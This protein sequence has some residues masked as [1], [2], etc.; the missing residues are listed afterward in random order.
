MAMK[1]HFVLLFLI[2]QL[3]LSFSASDQVNTLESV[4]DL[5]QS[6]YLTVN[7][8]PCVRLLNLSGEIGCASHETSLRLSELLSNDTGLARKVAGVL[9]ESSTK[10][11]NES[12]GFSPVEK[13]PQAEF[14]PYQKL[15][16]EWNPLGSSIM[17]SSYNFPIFLLDEDSTVVLQKIADKNEKNKQAYKVDVAEFNLVM[18]TTK[19][20]TH[21][22]ESCL[23]QQS[24][25]PLGGYSVMSSLPPI[26]VSSTQKPKSI[27]LAMASMD[28]ASF[29]RD[30]SPGADSP[31]SGMISLVAAVDALSHLGDL[32]E[33]NK[34]LVFLFF[35]GEAWGYLGSRRFLAELDMGTDAVHGLNSSLIE[36]V[37][38]IGSVGK[39][40]SQGVS[41]F[42]AH[43][44]R[45]LPA[46]KKTLDAF[47]HAHN[48]LRSDSINIS[49]AS[50]S[51]PGIPPS[52]LM[53][54]MRKFLGVEDV[55]SSSIGFGLGVEDVRSSLIAL[56]DGIY[57]ATRSGFSAILQNPLTSGVVLEDFDSAFSNKFYHS[58]L[59]DLS[60]IDSKS[61][62]AAASLVARTLYILATDGKILNTT[63]LNSINVNS[64]LVDELLGC[65]LT[66]EPGLSCALVKGYITPTSTCP[67]HY[68]GVI[69]GPP[70]S[71][72]YVEDLRDT[73]RFLW[74]FL[75]EKT[76]KPRKENS[77][78]CSKD[79][80]SKGGV[81]IRAETDGKGTCVL[82]TTRYIPAYSTRLKFDTGIWNLLPANASDVMGMVDPVWTE[83]FW[84]EIGLR[85]YTVQNA[86]YDRFVL[87]G[88]ISVAVLAY[89]AMIVTKAIVTKALKRD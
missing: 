22:S 62:V 64:S 61:L 30:K 39:G 67:N 89:L 57:S 85:A 65:L 12:K 56:L 19:S 81:C 27:V 70:S 31:L 35:T 59:D 17:W 53:A 37:L 33:L 18:Q 47:R 16:Y 43:A 72:P 78:I 21:D 79:C 38:E 63:K 20:G 51:N 25:L 68:V 76:S 26:D 40:F 75:A 24:C 6:M 36:M 11:Q 46:T 23:K 88:G 4:P 9:V 5:E 73:S 10:L 44:S 69:L 80:S 48:S 77:T 1:H 13:F 54:F 2:S 15:N 3:H 83:S 50:S 42:F 32:D 8:Y 58:Q 41:S 71:T 28:S 14:S 84:S 55:M 29:F 86:A 49:M 66:C 60:N 52:S 87:L 7:G 45:D 82:S 34:Q 74:N